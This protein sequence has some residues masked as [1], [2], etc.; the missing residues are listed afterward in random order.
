MK[1]EDV[2]MTIAAVGI[3]VWSSCTPAQLDQAKA[4]TDAREYA[5]RYLELTTEPELAEARKRCQQ[6]AELA[7]VLAVAAGPQACAEVHGE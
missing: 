6:G 5:C 7:E 2:G 4:A 1:A 3:S